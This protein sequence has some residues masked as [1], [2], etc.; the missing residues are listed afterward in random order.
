MSNPNNLA[1]MGEVPPAQPDPA[2]VERLKQAV[3][4]NG[5]DL[6]L[7]EGFVSIM[8]D[9]PSQ[10]QMQK[11]VGMPNPDVFMQTVIQFITEMI[12]A[13]VPQDLDVTGETG[14][15]PKR[16]IM[17]KK[18]SFPTIPYENEKA[19]KINAWFTQGVY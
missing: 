11:T 7:E 19:M 6:D 12:Y 14:F 18:V 3:F 4:E 17:L 13:H 2:G 8:V 15:D 16:P 10:E 1:D 5:V 9:F